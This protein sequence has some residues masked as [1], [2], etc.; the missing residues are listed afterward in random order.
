[1]LYFYDVYSNF[2]RELGVSNGKKFELFY[3]YWKVEF[4]EGMYNTINSS[5]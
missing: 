3:A 5:L 2:A 4:K 1:M